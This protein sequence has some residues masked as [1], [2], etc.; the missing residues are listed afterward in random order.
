M[1]EGDCLR[2][3][4]H[5]CGYCWNSTSDSSSTQRTLSSPLHKPSFKK[6]HAVGKDNDVTDVITDQ[7]Q[8]S[9][10][11]TNINNKHL[12]LFNQIFPPITDIFNPSDC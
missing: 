4:N 6:P 12:N 11:S 1:R 8:L 10:T 7:D 5:N 3:V 9:L 2:K